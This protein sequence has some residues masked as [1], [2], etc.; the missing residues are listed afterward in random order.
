MMHHDDDTAADDAPT[1]GCVSG[2]LYNDD[3]YDINIMVEKVTPN[4]IVDD[5]DIY[6]MVAKLEQPGVR[7]PA[8]RGGSLQ[9][10]KFV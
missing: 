10:K 6:I 8:R 3:D 4:R 9:R 7:S 2:N 5:D 1:Q